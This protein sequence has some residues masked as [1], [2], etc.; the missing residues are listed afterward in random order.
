MRI[1]QNHLQKV[2]AGVHGAQAFCI[3]VAGCLAL[4]VLTKSGGMSA[5]TGYFFGL[6][7]SLAAALMRSKG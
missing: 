4:A 2:K 5:T 3:F 7:W 1:P 6:V